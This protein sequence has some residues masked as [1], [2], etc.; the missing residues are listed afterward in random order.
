MEGLTF[1]YDD[2][3][4]VIRSWFI[5]SRI[6]NGLPFDWCP[7]WYAGFP[8]LTFY[9]FIIEIFTVC[10]TFLG[11]SLLFAFKIVVALLTIL[12]AI[13]LFFLARRW[14]GEK[15]A[16][17]SSVL[18]FLMPRYTSFVEVVGLRIFTFGF[19]LLP[20]QILLFDVALKLE[21]KK[22][23]ILSGL[24]FGTLITFHLLSAYSVA[25]IMGIYVIIHSLKK[26]NLQKFLSKVK[27]M[28]FVILIGLGIAAF[29]IVPYFVEI[30]Y[31][32]VLGRVFQTPKQPIQILAELPSYYGVIPTLC[33]ILGVV[34][35]IRKRKTEHM[36]LVLWFLTFV[37][38]SFGP[39]G[40]L[41]HILPFHEGLE[42]LRFENYLTQPVAILV[43]LFVSEVIDYVTKIKLK[44]RTNQYLK[45][46]F[47]ILVIVA[48]VSTAI[49]FAPRSLIDIQGDFNTQQ[50]TDYEEFCDALEWLKS[51]ET[52]GRILVHINMCDSG[53]NSYTLRS[54][55]IAYL[56]F[57]T[58]KP[59]FYGHMH[60][61]SSLLSNY[62]IWLTHDTPL[63]SEMIYNML[64]VGNVEYVMLGRESS[65]ALFEIFNSSK[66]FI[67]EKDF[68]GY[69]T[70]SVFRL[71]YNASLVE[72]PDVV[73]LTIAKD[74]SLCGEL[75]DIIVRREGG[76]RPVIV[77]GESEFLD[78][79]SLS[80]L[81]R[82]DGVA[83][84]NANYH[85]KEKALT[86]LQ[87]YEEEGG[88]IFNLT[89][90]DSID[91]IVSLPKARQPLKLS[92]QVIGDK[93]LINTSNIDPHTPILLKFSEFPRWEASC[94]GERLKIYKVSPEFM[95]VFLGE[96]E[97]QGVNFEFVWRKE[98][99]IGA[100]V[101]LVT[102]GLCAIILVGIKLGKKGCF[103]KFHEA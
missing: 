48:V 47:S 37:I 78:D 83:Y 56:P 92:Y 13:T 91:Y 75:F 29:W 84:Y 71:Q 103:K 16:L 100:A 55:T 68:Q 2:P 15:A 65:P 14:F 57:F 5:Y 85:D 43:G 25:M 33:A 27:V 88:K 52:D 59:L 24:V 7:Y 73:I 99:Y 61:E 39:H 97:A 66:R 10:I 62:T 53:I 28:L 31:S 98:N 89:M 44:N 20:L 32:W 72:I 82:F 51:I 1:G 9:P 93:V 76:Y 101:T 22:Y 12:P 21:D 49:I 35:A 17:V 81:K 46:G 80:E 40:L 42:Y 67:K 26:S 6:R 58:D 86:L 63:D 19:A 77:R 4:Y 74:E 8:T 41:W 18:L 45:K 38:I 30:D 11:T 94:N 3:A 87:K 79:Y 34:F 95:L 102:L 90:I 54:S 23:I 60:A 50:I 69:Q 36:V 70:I 96:G 64:R